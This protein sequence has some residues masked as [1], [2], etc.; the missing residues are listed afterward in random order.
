MNSW[1]NQG[2]LRRPGRGLK[3]KRIRQQTIQKTA[4]HTEFLTLPFDMHE[5]NAAIGALDS[6]A[7]APQALV[8]E[9]ISLDRLPDSFEALKKRTTQ[10]KVL[11]DP[12]GLQAA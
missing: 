7:F 2:R 10:C 5:F 8:S 3:S 11:V 4:S 6:G 1:L 9:T 12:F